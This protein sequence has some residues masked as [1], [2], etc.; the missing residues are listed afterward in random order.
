MPYF[1]K[2]NNIDFQISKKGELTDDLINR[3]PS[4][5]WRAYRRP[6]CRKVSAFEDWQERLAGAS[7]KVISAG[8][9]YFSLGGKFTAEN[10]KEYTYKITPT[11]CFAFPVED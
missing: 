1:I 5:I 9:S 11:Y 10:G 3:S 6:S 4:N 8:S 2:F 7:V